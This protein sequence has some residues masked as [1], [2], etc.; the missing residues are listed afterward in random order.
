M[1]KKDF[2]YPPKMLQDW[3]EPY[4]DDLGIEAKSVQSYISFWLSDAPRLPDYAK[5][6]FDA[7]NSLAVRDPWQFCAPPDTVEGLRPRDFWHDALGLEG[8]IAKTTWN[9]QN[10][11]ARKLSDATRA[12]IQER[13]D[14]YR[15]RMRAAC[16][17][18]EWDARLLA[19]FK[20]EEEPD[21]FGYDKN[22]GGAWFSSKWVT[23]ATRHFFTRE[24]CLQEIVAT[25]PPDD[26]RRV[27]ARAHALSKVEMTLV[28]RLTC[29]QTYSV[30]VTREDEEWAAAWWAE[31]GEDLP[32]VPKPFLGE[33]FVNVGQYTAT[34]RTLA[35]GALQ[36][37][38]IE[39]KE[40]SD[41]VWTGRQYKSKNSRVVAV[42]RDGAWVAPT[43]EDLLVIEYGFV[44]EIEPLEDKQSL[45]PV[46]RDSRLF[47]GFDHVGGMMTKRDMQPGEEELL[48]AEFERHWVEVVEP[49]HQRKIAV[50][51][52]A[53][54]ETRQ[55]AEK[56]AVKHAAS[57]RL[58]EL[59]EE[60][61][62]RNEARRKLRL[63]EAIRKGTEPQ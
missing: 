4:R 52:K 50:R 35:E 10:D 8:I 19:G 1:D 61:T 55:Q 3:L 26:A 49:S 38:S 20:Q 42:K 56:D 18:Q 57:R 2:F 27:A 24:E 11:D 9:N 16:T 43:E 28:N 44:W 22:A 34:A 31:V 7:I 60:P 12:A 39:Y 23:E 21:Y 13:L 36:S 29:E 33:Q 46:F 58:Q 48:R 51:A 25:M 15:V 40:E 63:V 54:E 45:W 62:D 14:D 32:D 47:E 17:R 5:R 41:F 30:E 59:L 6:A 37:R 53:L